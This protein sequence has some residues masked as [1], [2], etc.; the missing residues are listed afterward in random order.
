MDFLFMGCHLSVYL[1][2]FFSTFYFFLLILDC[3]I[4]LFSL[5]GKALLALTYS[6]CRQSTL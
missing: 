6:A 1:C 3:F 2:L 5:P 4:S